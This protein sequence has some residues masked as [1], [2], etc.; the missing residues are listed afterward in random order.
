MTIGAYLIYFVILAMW[1]E[2]VRFG[3]FYDTPAP[4]VQN[5]PK[6]GHIPRLQ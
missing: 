3:V 4:V 2:S 5:P 1:F 6:L